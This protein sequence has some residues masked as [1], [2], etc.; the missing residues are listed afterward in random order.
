[1]SFGHF[2]VRWLQD[3]RRSLI[4]PDVM[5]IV[6]RTEMICSSVFISSFLSSQ[7]ELTRQCHCS[8]ADRPQRMCVLGSSHATP[9]SEV[10]GL[11]SG[12]NTP[13]LIW[14]P[15]FIFSTH[16]LG[17]WEGGRRGRGGGAG[18]R[19]KAQSHGAV[20]SSLD[21]LLTPHTWECWRLGEVCSDEGAQRCK[22]SLLQLDQ[23]KKRF[24]KLRWTP[25]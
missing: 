13:H 3:W 21:A 11:Q 17:K 8:L 1:M 5:I 20:S 16:Q 10:S 6:I 23:A 12:V 24:Q 2:I 14:F 7:H 19:R 22:F 25:I 18:V 15:C 4:C 9:L